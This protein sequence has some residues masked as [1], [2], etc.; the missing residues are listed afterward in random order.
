MLI[1]WSSYS[2]HPQLHLASFFY[3]FFFIFLNIN[4]LILIGGSYFTVLYWFCHTSTWICHVCARVPHPEPPLPPL[5]PTVPLDHPSAPAPSTP[6]HAS[7]LD[8]RSV[9]NIHVSMPFSQIIP[10]SPTESKLGFLIPSNSF[11]HFNLSSTLDH[12][13]VLP[14]EEAFVKNLQF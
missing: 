14:L 13:L 9:Y 3:F 4:L 5:S 12:I 1:L 6:Y 11:S 8:W 7:N 2:I 10:P